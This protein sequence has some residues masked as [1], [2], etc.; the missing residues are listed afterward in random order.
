MSIIYMIP[1]TLLTMYIIAI[2][3]IYIETTKMRGSHVIYN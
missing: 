2:M 3:S 1:A